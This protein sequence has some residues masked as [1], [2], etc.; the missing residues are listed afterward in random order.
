[1]NQKE[2]LQAI[3]MKHY[4]DFLIRLQTLNIQIKNRKAVTNSRQHNVIFMTSVMR[5]LVWALLLKMR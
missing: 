1:M 3:G 5:T 4:Q 2:N